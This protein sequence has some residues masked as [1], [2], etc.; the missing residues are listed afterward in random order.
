[1]TKWIIVVLIGL[2]GVLQYQCWMGHGN[3]RD[4]MQLKNMIHIQKTELQ[5][6]VERNQTLEIDLEVL[7]KYPLACEE[8]A[9]NELGMIKEGEIFFVVTEPAH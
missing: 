7:K 8:R 2:L 1:M 9:R 5:T 3:I 6:L 4:I